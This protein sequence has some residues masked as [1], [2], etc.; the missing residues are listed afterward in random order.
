M[1]LMRSGGFQNTLRN[2]C[3]SGK[4]SG[5]FNL[6]TLDAAK[7]LQYDSQASPTGVQVGGYGGSAYAMNGT[8]MHVR[9]N[10]DAGA[11]SFFYHLV[12]NSPFS[13]GPLRTIHLQFDLTIPFACR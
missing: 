4:Q 11:N 10:N 7:Q 3:A 8:T 5:P 13:S 6:S 2:A 12:S 9:I 1:D